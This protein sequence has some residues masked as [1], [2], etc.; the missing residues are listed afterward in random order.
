MH[1]VIDFV[2]ETWEAKYN[3]DSITHN[4]LQSQHHKMRQKKKGKKR[5]PQVKVGKYMLVS[6]NR[7]MEEL[8]KLSKMLVLDVSDELDNIFFETT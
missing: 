1:R 4:E 7:G 8:W 2:Q 6:P 5:I 3:K